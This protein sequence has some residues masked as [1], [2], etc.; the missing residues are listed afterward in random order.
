MAHPAWRSPLHTIRDRISF[1]ASAAPLRVPS[2]QILDALQRSHPSIQMEALFLTATAMAQTLG[3][4]P[5]EMVSRAKRQLPDAE[6]PFTEQL[7]AAR[8]YA[9]GEL[10][11]A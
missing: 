4:D 10:R 7:Q 11:N 8:D 3:L 1:A 2:F 5:H 9:A 6:G